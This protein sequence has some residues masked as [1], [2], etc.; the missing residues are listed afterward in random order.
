MA[1]SAVMAVPL[2]ATTL[3]APAAAPAALS[4]PV[5]GMHVPWA[6]GGAHY[7]ERGQLTSEPEA[8]PD[9]RVPTVRLWDTR[10]TWADIEP[11][12]DAWSFAHLDAHLA[13]AEAHGTDD[14][15]FVLAGTP[16][17]AARDPQAPGA[18]WL[19]PGIASP[20]R[21]LSDWRDYVRTVAER[22][23]GVI[24]AYQIGNEPNLAWFWQGSRAE[25]TRLVRVAVEEIRAADPDAQI[26]APAPIVTSPASAVGAVRWWQAMNGTG[27]DALAIQWYPP[28]GA[29]PQDLGPILDRMRAGITGSDLVG[30]P[31]WIT[32]V[33]HRA[34]SGS[35]RALIDQTMRVAQGKGV[36]RV[37][38][39]AWTAIGPPGL[40]DLQA[41]K[42]AERALRHHASTSRVR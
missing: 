7:D 18:P 13:V 26:V 35:A 36:E 5:L 33:N 27:V 28:A 38:W 37:Y 22:Y 15:L 42:P 8:W 11:R 29:A 40:L 20:P 17:W 6:A 39:Y 32:E 10:T 4:P 9:F 16:A 30:T 23:V 12:D 31:V 21:N 24:D 19:S 14:V 2:L 3:L 1:L 34:R 25:L 41:G